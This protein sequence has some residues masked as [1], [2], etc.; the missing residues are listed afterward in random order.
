MHR[1]EWILLLV[2]LGAL[3]GPLIALKAVAAFRHKGPLPPPQPYRDDE[4]E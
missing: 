2:V 4:D 3:L 1:A